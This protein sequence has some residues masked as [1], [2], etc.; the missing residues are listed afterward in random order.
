MPDG[1]LIKL[2]QVTLFLYR[3][4]ILQNFYKFKFYAAAGNG[5]SNQFLTADQTNFTGHHSPFTQCPGL[6]GG[7]ISFRKFWMELKIS[8]VSL[9]GCRNPGHRRARGKAQEA[10][11]LLN[12]ATSIKKP[13]PPR[14][15]GAWAGKFNQTEF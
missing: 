15:S 9:R 5:R 14:G 13:R 10:A 6:I 1:S 11:A 2:W 4:F 8:R 12:R 3:G 7:H